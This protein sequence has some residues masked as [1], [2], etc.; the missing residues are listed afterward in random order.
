MIDFLRS[1]GGVE[2]KPSPN[3]QAEKPTLRKGDCGHWLPADVAPVGK[4]EGG[5]DLHLCE[6]CY[7]PK[8]PERPSLV[9]KPA[10]REDAVLRAGYLPSNLRAQPT[11]HIN[12]FPLGDIDNY[13]VSRHCYAMARARYHGENLANA[14]RKYAP[15]EAAYRQALAKHD[16]PWDTKAQGDYVSTVDGGA[17]A[18]E[19]WSMQ[20]S[21]LL[22]AFSVVGRLPVTRLQVPFRIMHLPKIT[23]DITIVYSGENNQI[24]ASQYQLGQLS[25]TARKGDVTIAV[26]NETMR[27]APQLADD[28]LRRS[29]AKAIAYDR[30]FQLLLGQGGP[31]PTG[32]VTMATAGVVSKYYPGGSGGATP[33]WA[34]QAGAAHQVP[35]FTHLSQLRGKV[36]QLNGSTLVTPATGQAHCNGM[37]AHS[38]LEQEVLIQS[39]ANGPWTDANGRPL[40]MSGL[41]RPESAFG[42]DEAGSG[43]LLGQ[44]FALTNILPTNSTDGGGTTSSFIVA[45][46][47]QQYA[48]FEAL[49]LAYDTTM[50]ASYFANDQTGVRVLSRGDGAPIH[51]EAFAVLAGAD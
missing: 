37:I 8:Q 5:N 17:L 43:A 16:P 20:W 13:S 29:S 25:Y 15:W 46:W 11:V 3:G 30:D 28:L 49:Q 27:D 19:F 7:Q 41:E 40:W 12:A 39:G 2:Q 51:P 34:L 14:L 21:D 44:I 48:W 31:N 6:R 38:R 45:G 47:W 32:L 35:A 26:S 1:R 42:P 24:T 36:H 50:E 10:S 22:R 23:G 18:P 9:Q 4:D 33:T